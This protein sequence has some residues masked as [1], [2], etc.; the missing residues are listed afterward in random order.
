M[1]K[2]NLTLLGLGY[3]IEFKKYLIWGDPKRRLT[4]WDIFF[5]MIAV[6]PLLEIGRA[7]V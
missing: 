3:T 6:I 1:Q 2:P 5:S 7:H 4:G